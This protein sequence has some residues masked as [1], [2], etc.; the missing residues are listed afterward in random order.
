MGMRYGSIRS[1]LIRYTEGIGGVVAERI[2]HWCPRSRA[3]KQMRLG[4]E[5][6]EVY[7]RKRRGFLYRNFL[8]TFVL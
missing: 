3:E 1:V 4:T 8:P 2:A 5:E 6:G 7:T